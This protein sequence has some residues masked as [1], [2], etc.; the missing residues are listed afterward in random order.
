MSPEQVRG[1]EADHR[2]D[3]F[4]FGLVLYEMLSGRRPFTGDTA[5]EVMTAI[6]KQD[7]PGL[8]TS[9]PAAQREIVRHCLEKEPAARFQSAK[10]L[11]F[12]L[13][14]LLLD[15]GASGSLP[16]IAT[17]NPRRWLRYAA[18]AAVVAAAFG[19]GWLAN[20]KKEFDLANYHFTPIASEADLEL[21]PVWA[22]DGKSL[23]YAAGIRGGLHI[24]TR[25]LD[26]PVADQ[27][28]HDASGRQ[29]FWSRNGDR[30][31]FTGGR[32]GQ[33]E[34]WSVAAIGGASERVLPDVSIAALAPDG[35]SM[36]VARSDGLAF[37]SLGGSEWR[38]Y[39]KAPFDRDFAARRLQFSRDGTKL[40]VLATR[41]NLNQGEIW[42]VPYPPG[43][44]A[45][46]KLFAALGNEA[47]FTGLSWMPDS[48]HMAVAFDRFDEPEQLYLFDS[49]T[50]NL[51]ELTSGMETGTSPAVSPDGRR[52]AYVQE[53]RDN[54][55]VEI[56]LDGSGTRPFLTTARAERSG[57]WLPGGRELVYIS[58]ANGPF[59]L[60]SRN[61]EEQRSRPLLSSGNDGLSV[62]RLD[63]V[64]PA[65]DGERFA[66]ELWG[67]EHTIRIMRRSG[68]RAVRIDAENQDHHS[69][70]WSPDGNWIAYARVRP[71]AQLMKVPAGGGAPVAISKANVQGGPTQVAWSPAG[72]W[73]AWNAGALTVYSPDG[74]KQKKLADAKPRQSIGF[75]A[76]GKT[77]Y[78][79]YFDSRG[80][81]WVLDGIDVGSGRTQRI[82]SFELDASSSLEGFSLHPDGKRLMATLVKNNPAIV[83]LEGF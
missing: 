73:I 7:P 30:I 72:D 54:D 64:V 51:R 76:N 15:S 59:Q 6:L 42:L 45:P 47:E 69:P 29:P 10:D 66:V 9:L 78:T 68:G 11:S 43:Q 37:G 1:Q 4:S 74:K 23:A 34:L 77:L 62:G 31:Y 48:R 53:S 26:S 82:G 49:E 56:M 28:T 44:G 61:T 35:V 3:I 33:S 18:M 70:S 21:D 20:R 17:R 65:P 36:A 2:S 25:R 14:A 27:I 12:A 38:P 71:E 60:W 22:P 32:A 16:A 41:V 39:R 79:Y 58:N 81:N 24:F 83:L 52:I 8:P 80:R 5:A 13:R 46:R 63:R 57:F 50:G 55:L 19:G 75:S 40:A 67:P